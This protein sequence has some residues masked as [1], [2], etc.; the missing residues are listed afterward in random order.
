MRFVGSFVLG[1]LIIVPW[2]S[3]AS[4]QT[5][6]D[7][8]LV[9]I[10]R[11]AGVYRAVGEPVNITSRPGYD[12]QPHFEPD[13]GS[14][15]FTS[16][17]DGD[18][19]IYRYEMRSRRTIQLTKTSENEY[20]PTVTPDGR[21]FTVIRGAQQFLERFTREGRDPEIVIRGITPVGYHAWA[22]DE[23]LLLFVLGQPI[24]L[25]RASARTGKSDTVFNAPG[26]SL[27]RIPGRHAVS[28]IQSRGENAFWIVAYD[29]DSRQV[30]PIARTVAGSNDRDMAWTPDGVIVMT[31]GNSIYQL[32]PL[33][34]SEW[35]LLGTFGTPGMH[36]LTRIAVSPRGDWLAVVGD[37]AP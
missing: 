4:G 28:A 13:R 23:T 21:G 10:E 20:S 11:S 7:I 19:D 36:R 17:R 34:D 9:R 32:D 26:R 30:A 37:E 6:S 33:R 22:D 27:H 3:T 8:F 2:F 25:Q 29:L 15:L 14:V 18:T 35:R 12:N 31:A 24:T 5:G 1:A 16:D